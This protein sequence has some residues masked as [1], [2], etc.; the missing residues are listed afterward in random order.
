M[1]IYIRVRTFNEWD[2]LIPLLPYAERSLFRSKK[3]AFGKTI[4]PVGILTF[5]TETK[6]YDFINMIMNP[7]DKVIVDASTIIERGFDTVLFDVLV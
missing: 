5:N 2:D 6:M 3:D 1:K 4:R 7:E